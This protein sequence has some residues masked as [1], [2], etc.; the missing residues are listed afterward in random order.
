MII[1]SERA[2]S[3][4]TAKKSNNSGSVA[5]AR[6]GDSAKNATLTIQNG[7]FEGL[8]IPLKKARTLLGRAVD[9]DICLDDSLVS[10]EHAAIS[11]KGGDFVL[12]DLNSRNGTSVTGERIN[13]RKLRN[14]DTIS[15]GNFLLKFKLK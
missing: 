10:D 9:C 14:G 4:V 12:E 1:Y 3:Q 8:V 2:G 5:V 13:Q 15:I 6:K 11:R 7:C